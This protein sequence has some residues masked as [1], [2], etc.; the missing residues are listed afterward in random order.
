[1][2]H[3]LVRIILRNRLL[4]LAI[5]LSLTVF[6]AF[7]AF[8]LK[9][10]YEMTQMLPSSDSTS[11]EYKHFKEIFGED[12]SVMFIG[13]QSKDLFSLKEFNDWWDLTYSIKAME[14]VGEVVSLA[15]IYTLHKDDQERK[16]RFDLVFRNKPRSQAELDSLK[17]VVF[18]IPFYNG[19]LLNQ[20][21]GATLMMIT[22][23]KEQTRT[24]TL[25]RLVRD[26]VDLTDKFGHN[27][28]IKVHYSGL[29][30]IRIKIAEKLQREQAFFVAAALLMAVLLLLLFFRSFKAAFFTMI[31]VIMNVIWVLGFMGLFGYKLTILSGIIPPLL[32]VI[33]VENCIFLLNKYH[34]EFILHGNKAKALSRM[35]ER[36]GNAN[37]LTN[38]ATAA[39]FLSFVVTGNKIL[40]EFGII[41][42]ISIMV[43]YLMCL[44]LVPIIFSFLPSP[45]QRHTRH[46]E[47]S[48]VSKIVN[49]VVHIVQFHRTPVY[50]ITIVAILAGIGGA[51]RLKSS[52]RIVDDLSKRD[53]ISKDM[54]FMEEHFK[55]VMPFEISIDSKKKKGAM[56]LSTIEKIDEMQKILATYPELSKS[57]SIADVV[58]FSRQAF[59]NGDS[60][61]YGM[62]NS[63]ELGFMI[64]YLPKMEQNKRTIINSFID[65][66]LQ[67]TRIS[68]QMAN[69]QTVDIQRIK[70]DLRPKIDSI[71][72]KEDFNVGMTGTSV[73]FLEGSKYLINH[74]FMSLLLAIAIIALLMVLLFTSPRMI[75]ISII[76]NL[77]PL[78][79]TAGMMGY[80]G[81]T[82]RPSTVIIFSI[83]LGISVDNAIQYLSRYRLNLMTSKWNI[84]TSVIAALKE[85]G[86]SMIYSS[87]VL[88]FGFAIFIT[89]T[90]GGTVALGYLISFTLG[91]ALL[92]NLFIL[93]SLLLTLDNYITTKKFREPLIEIFDEV[94]DIELEE[95]EIEKKFEEAALSE[96]QE[97]EANPS[98]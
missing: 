9:I 60:S 49:Q 10:S 91:M 26:I 39:G 3:H 1:M 28:D 52:G 32:I 83:A 40:T 2:F 30:Y 36:I 95:L 18:S 54:M 38:A 43:A 97:D 87:V 24:R 48:N 8:R 85:T 25:V 17:N 41:A 42:S 82:I 34:H 74:L 62:P 86:F 94:I 56:K 64:R 50:I 6:M 29:P 98:K 84:K 90:F 14:G 70:D 53:R 4:N 88:F 78:V 89:S 61:Y 59:Y 80:F 46:I 45:S 44:F 51:M 81:I 96:K 27:N 93:P 55:G 71:F 31:I 37:L 47:K 73:V 20:E 75:L 92:C 79:L 15:R 57:L 76:P 19:F 22:L 33:V 67:V 21:T 12:G 77:I 16:L 66:N 69:I 72:P 58:K 13:I 5:I 65:T 68:T 23:D 7:M 35:V 11:I 63:Q